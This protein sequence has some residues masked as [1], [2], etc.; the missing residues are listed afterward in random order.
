MKYGFSKKIW[1][2][3]LDKLFIISWVTCIWKNFYIN[4]NNFPTLKSIKTWNDKN[5]IKN[6]QIFFENDK[7][8]KDLISWL[9]FDF[10][11]INNNFYSYSLEDYFIQ[12]KEFWNVY[13]DISIES[14]YN[15]LQYFPWKIFILDFS[16]DILQKN[17]KK[18][19]LERGYWEV[20]VKHL[21]KTIKKELVMLEEIKK[22][23]IKILSL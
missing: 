18:R 10:Y 14:I 7:F 11:S 16:Q 22:E 4:S 5:N 3:D 17:I 13:I 6:N 23:S 15:W 9:Y 21:L 20:K 2:I 19:I 1:K 12:S 8:Y